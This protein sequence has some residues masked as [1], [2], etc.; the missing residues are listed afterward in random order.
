ML[1]KWGGGGGI[2]DKLLE[3]EACFISCIVGLSVS[4][5]VSLP[6]AAQTLLYL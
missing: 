2:C 3:E 4:E 1:I 6:L 5:P